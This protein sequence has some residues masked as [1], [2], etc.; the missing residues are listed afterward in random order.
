MTT[1]L[2]ALSVKIQFLSLKSEQIEGETSQAISQV[3]F[4][5]KKS[6]KN[7]FINEISKKI[8]CLAIFHQ[9]KIAAEAHDR[10]M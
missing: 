1:S 5:A 10:K 2:H 8:T 3:K 6:L 9:L 7:K 4:S